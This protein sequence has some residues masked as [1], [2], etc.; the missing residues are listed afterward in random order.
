VFHA[1]RS[2]EGDKEKFIWRLRATGKVQ[3]VGMH[4]PAELKAI[5]PAEIEQDWKKVEELLS[6]A[7]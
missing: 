7:A 3:A 4:L 2:G 6:K 1:E 5:F